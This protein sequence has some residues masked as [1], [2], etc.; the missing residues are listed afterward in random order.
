MKFSD[1]EK[2][3][4]YELLRKEEPHLVSDD[5]FQFTEEDKAD[6]VNTLLD[7]LHYDII[8]DWQDGYAKFSFGNKEVVI[9][10]DDEGNRGRQNYIDDELN[11]KD[12]EELISFIKDYCDNL[13]EN[14]SGKKEKKVDSYFIINSNMSQRV[15]KIAQEFLP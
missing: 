6:G 13:V 4:I 9:F 5:L 3:K 14:L 11:D 8:S 12:K 7:K 2:M 15:K 1:K 10:K